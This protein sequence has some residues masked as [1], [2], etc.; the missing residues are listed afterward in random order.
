M[1]R[2]DGINVGVHAPLGKILND[3]KSG[4]GDSERWSKSP[5]LATISE[6]LTVVFP[7]QKFHY[8]EIHNHTLTNI[9]AGKAEI[10]QPIAQYHHPAVESLGIR[11]DL[12]LTTPKVVMYKSNL[13]TEKFPLASQHIF[14]S[15]TFVF[16]VGYITAL[17]AVK[18]LRRFE[19]PSKLI[20]VEFCVGLL[21]DM[22]T[23]FL[24][25]IFTVDAST[26]KIT[27]LT[28]I[29]RNVESGRAKLLSS[30][31]AIRSLLETPSSF[32]NSNLAQRFQRIITK[33]PCL[34]KKA[35]NAATIRRLVAPESKYLYIRGLS[36]SMTA[37]ANHCGLRVHPLLELPPD[38][39]GMYSRPGRLMKL[40]SRARITTMSNAILNRIFRLSQRLDCP[41]EGTGG[42]RMALSLAQIRPMLLMFLALFCI[43]IVQGVVEILG[44]IWVVVGWMWLSCCRAV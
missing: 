32:I 18:V 19:Q 43:C 7:A 8:I 37:T 40:G 6:I 31:P 11:F 5:V 30:S 25:L 24:T 35:T 2:T 4:L 15:E 29:L 16:L 38:L 21:L 27:S 41:G 39:K 42:P 9:M 26:D 13:F 23:S 1:K 10:S 44:S 36:A 14:H 12:I 17:T 33:D 22:M 28:G 3:W 20:F 34:V